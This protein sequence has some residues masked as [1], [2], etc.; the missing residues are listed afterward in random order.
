[1]NGVIQGDRTAEQPDD[2]AQPGDPKDIGE[3]DEEHD[4][5]DSRV[6]AAYTAGE[7][8][9]DAEAPRPARTSSSVVRLLGLVVLVLGGIA[10]GLVLGRFLIELF[11]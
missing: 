4:T 10:L 5:D 7:D 8:D 6:V 1:V 2:D 9:E 3:L 11:Q